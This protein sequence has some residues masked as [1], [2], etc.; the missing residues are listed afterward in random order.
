MSEPAL[1]PSSPIVGRFN[2]WFFDT[3][4][5]FIDWSMR[6]IKPQ[7]YRNLPS[8]IVEIGPGVGSNFR[9]YMPGTTVIGIEPN[10]AMHERL[11]RNAEQAG[12][13]LDLRATLAESTGLPRA[14]SSVVISNLV[15]C[16]V[17]DPMQAAEEAYRILE[18]G[19]VLYLVEHVHGRGRL[20]RG[21][22]RL[23]RRP[24]KW[25]FEGCELDR[26]TAG[27][28][29]SVGFETSGISNT[30]VITPFVPVNSLIFGK[31]V[32][33]PTSQVGRSV[34]HQETSKAMGRK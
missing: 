29:S 34:A 28:L 4:D 21:V 22:Q 15:L 10:F 18:P 11:R 27:T 1:Y 31:A 33:E 32:K 8:S 25:L 13:D 3:F 16:T 17:T 26:D 23:V 30:T 7:V 19:G 6:R 5:G 14:S 2:A 9:Y 20:L 12:I 24:W